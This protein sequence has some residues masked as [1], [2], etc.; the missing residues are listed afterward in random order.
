MTAG[1]MTWGAPHGTRY[2]RHAR[3][4]CAYGA[5]FSGAPR[6]KLPC[7]SGRHA[8]VRRRP[9]RVPRTY[10]TAAARVNVNT[11]EDV[12]EYGLVVRVGVEGRRG[13]GHQAREHLVRVR[14]GVRVRVRVGVGVRV[15]VRVRWSCSTSVS[16]N[17]RLVPGPCEVTTL[18]STTRG[19]ST[20]LEAEE[21]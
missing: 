16:A 6:G 13:E 1:M 7:A 11:T 15:R 4:W 17:C 21:T 3:G 9:V 20:Q 18:P 19:E 10:G 8:R 5:R 14:V 2:V 12:V